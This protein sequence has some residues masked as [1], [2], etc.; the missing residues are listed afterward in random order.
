MTRTGKHTPPPRVDRD[1]SMLD[2]TYL[3]TG[4]FQHAF[5]Q[6]GVADNTWVYKVPA[7]FGYIVPY[8]PSRSILT[9][10]S[11]YEHAL[12]LALLRLPDAV[13]NRLSRGLAA[14]RAAHQLRYLPIP[15]AALQRFC[16]R[17]QAIGRRLIAA[18]A[19]P[20]RRRKFCLTLGVLKYLVEQSLD[21]IPLPFKI[22]EA[23]EA[24]LRVNGQAM[25][26]RGPILVQRK[27]TCLFESSDGFASCDWG[28][29][30][31]KVDR[32]WRH[33]VGLSEV[34]KPWAVLDGHARLFDTS[35]VTR[36]A[37]KVWRHLSEERMERRERIALREWA[38][39][40]SDSS[41]SEYCR[42]IRK[43]I[44][45][46]RMRQLWGADLKGRSLRGG[47]KA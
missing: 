21:D 47:P 7:A 17:G 42:F 30:V 11:F 31:R 41:A 29:V 28:E 19:R 23:G 9:P 27:A 37:E 22:L 20:R 6:T 10:H 1:S 18:Y 45:Q 3:A 40:S 34:L 38:R 5:T 14:Y 43:Q 35:G 32:L 33:G 15:L 2:L 44:T 26:Y 16:D 36:D 8:T 39:V 4:S 12:K 13:C 24:V 46:D 25:P